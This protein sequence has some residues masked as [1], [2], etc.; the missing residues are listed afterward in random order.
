MAAPVRFGI[1]STAHINR[2]VIPPAHASD[3][4]ELIAV[5]CAKTQGGCVTVEEEVGAQRIDLRCRRLVQRSVGASGDHA[6]QRH[7]PGP[8]SGDGGGIR[9]SFLHPAEHDAPASFVLH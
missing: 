2:L 1:I 4:V 9:S 3:K 8:S 5:E 7:H 6:R